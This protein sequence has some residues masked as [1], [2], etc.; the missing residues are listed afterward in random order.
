[1]TVRCGGLDGASFDV[2]LF[3]RALLGFEVDFLVDFV[4]FLNFEEVSFGL[5]FFRRYFFFKQLGCL[6][7][8]RF[9]DC[10]LEFLDLIFK[11]LPGLLVRLML[12]GP[13]VCDF[14]RLHGRFLPVNRYDISQ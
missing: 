5:F 6:L 4:V 9:F 7:V 3:L 12:L 2:V 14:L 10:G 1:M 11:L 8:F 13:H